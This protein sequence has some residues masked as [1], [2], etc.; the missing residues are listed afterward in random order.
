MTKQCFKCRAVLPLDEF[1]RHPRMADGHLNK[2]KLC[3]RLDVMANRVRKLQYYREYDRTRSAR[4]GSSG[5]KLSNRRYHRHYPHK[6]AAHQ[7]TSVAIR[8]GRLIRQPCEVCGHEPAEA[9]HDDYSKPLDVRWLCT[10][11]HAEHHKRERERLRNS[12]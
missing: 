4:S 6:R 1:Y 7:A 5:D 10:K 11:H 9:H 12:A 2:C 3:A 8:D